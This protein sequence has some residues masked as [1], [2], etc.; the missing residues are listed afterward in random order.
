MKE[1]A[2]EEQRNEEGV[3]NDEKPLEPT[4]ESGI[5]FHALTGY[6]PFQTLVIQGM[7][8]KVPISILVDSGSTHNFVNPQT[9]KHVGC[10]ILSTNN[11]WITVVDGSRV[12]NNAICP[13]FQWRMNRDEFMADMNYYYWGAII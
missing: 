12:S 4:T 11:L 7:S 8:K 3:S 10:S 6:T 5:S 2:V 13:G 9:A 1:N